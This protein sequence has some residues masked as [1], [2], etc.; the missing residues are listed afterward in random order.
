M[1]KSFQSIVKV[2]FAYNNFEADSIKEYIDCV[3]TQFLEEY[4]I[5]LSDSEITVGDCLED[6]ASDIDELYIHFN[7]DEGRQL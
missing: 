6:L 2:E 7:C 4:N 3:K 1:K 5:E